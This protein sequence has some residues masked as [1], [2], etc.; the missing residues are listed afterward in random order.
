[1][2]VTVYGVL[3]FLRDKTFYRMYTNQES[4]WITKTRFSEIE[5][6]YKPSVTFIFS[7]SVPIADAADALI[8]ANNSVV[9]SEQGS[10]Q[11]PPEK[12][13]VDLTPPAEIY[14][15]PSVIS[16]PTAKGPQ[17]ELASLVMGSALDEDMD[18]GSEGMSKDPSFTDITLTIPQ[19]VIDASKSG[20]QVDPKIQKKLDK[21]MKRIERDQKKQAKLRKKQQRADKRDKEKAMKQVEK[22]RKS[23][24]KE[25]NKALYKA[26]KEARKKALKE[27]EGDDSEGYLPET[28]VKSA[29]TVDPLSATSSVVPENKDAG[30]LGK[31]YGKYTTVRHEIL[32][33]LFCI[34]LL[35]WFI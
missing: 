28:P 9:T 14:G 4:H 24:A 34:Y 7:F 25:Q 8:Y 5:T 31:W 2:I 15:T 13:V 35:I 26:E 21:D 10:G 32:Q 16:N 27:A 1:M 17:S 3:Y 18:Y 29:S 11:L 19:S 23:K 30:K 22:D 20:E 6:N 12:S 33:V